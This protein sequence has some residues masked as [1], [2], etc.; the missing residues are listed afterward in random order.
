M[1]NVCHV[2]EEELLGQ[3]REQMTQQMRFAPFCSIRETS[4]R[5]K[6]RMQ[7]SPSIG[8]GTNKIGSRVGGPWQPVDG[9]YSF[10]SRGNI[11]L[12]ASSAALHTANFTLPALE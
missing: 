2:G 8:A 9:L 11:A 4:W 5:I 6:R 1:K 10:T 3:L 7:A 12:M